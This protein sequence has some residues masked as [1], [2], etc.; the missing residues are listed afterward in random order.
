MLVYDIRYFQRFA[1]SMRRCLGWRVLS[2][3]VL[4]LNTP[5]CCRSSS[6]NIY[7]YIYIYMSMYVC[8]CIMYI[9]IYIH[10]HICIYAC[11]CI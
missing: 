4:V 9:Y 5:R 6:K 3:I 11:M 1:P 10:I 8:I 7:I 2:V